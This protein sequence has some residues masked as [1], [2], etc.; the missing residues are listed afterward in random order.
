[1]ALWDDQMAICNT[2]ATGVFGQP[3]SYQRPGFDPFDIVGIPEFI[4]R[5]EDVNTGQFYSVFYQTADFDQASFTAQV[6]A[7]ITSIPNADDTVT[8]DEITYTAVLSLNNAVPYQFLRGSSAQG[9]ASN[10]TFAINATSAGAGTFF[11]SATTAHP[12][13]TASWADSGTFAIVTVSA[14]IPGIAGDQLAASDDMSGLNL[15]AQRFYG[16]GPV[17]NDLVTLDNILFRVS[18]V[19]LPD[20]YGSIQIRLEKKAI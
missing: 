5:L 9:A 15:D 1:M 19:P 10:L 12:T 2:F 8:F 13:C 7:K 20:C 16:G 17:A 14:I 11:S 18:D 4:P 3:T 6:N